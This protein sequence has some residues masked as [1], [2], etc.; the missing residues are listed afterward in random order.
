MQAPQRETLLACEECR[1][2]APLGFWPRSP[3]KTGTVVTRLAAPRQSNSP[4]GLGVECY[5]STNFTPNAIYDPATC[6]RTTLAAAKKRNF[7]AK[8]LLFEVSE[9]EDAVD[10]EH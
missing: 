3:T 7:S 4:P 10:K 2:A 5:L 9:P 6:I 1:L 8:R